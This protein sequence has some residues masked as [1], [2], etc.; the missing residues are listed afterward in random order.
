[1]Y[2]YVYLD[3]VLRHILAETAYP[4]SLIHQELPSYKNRIVQSY[5]ITFNRTII[6]D[7]ADAYVRL[8][9]SKQELK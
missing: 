8:L 3:F 5:L 1:M 7:F 2:T 6:L 4:A 9:L